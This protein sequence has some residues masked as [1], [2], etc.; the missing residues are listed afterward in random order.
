MK[1]LIF[2]FILTVGTALAEDLTVQNVGH[3]DYY[4]GSCETNST[5]QHFGS[6]DYIN[7]RK[8]GSRS[9]KMGTCSR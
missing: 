5:I 7:G 8:M 2:F 9:A 3:V 1:A 6:T 4:N